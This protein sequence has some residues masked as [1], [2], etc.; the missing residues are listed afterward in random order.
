MQEA[1]N[2]ISRGELNYVRAMPRYFIEEATRDFFE[3]LRLPYVAIFLYSGNAALDRVCQG[4][5]N[6]CKKISASLRE[7]VEC[8]HAF[9]GA[10]GTVG[11]DT[12][13]ILNK[14]C[15]GVYMFCAI[16]L[17]VSALPCSASW[18]SAFAAERGLPSIASVL[19]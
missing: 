5:S 9:A 13:L 15:L 10:V 18:R 1:T 3:R 8:V 17:L 7:R 11:L 16:E 14:W 2:P 4:I 6:P 12:D 19:S